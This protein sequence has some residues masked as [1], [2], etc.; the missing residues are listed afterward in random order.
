M[1]LRPA[2]ADIQG[3]SPKSLDGLPRTAFFW[4][5]SI[6]LVLNR[7]S[8]AVPCRNFL[9]SVCSMHRKPPAPSSSGFVPYPEPGE[10]EFSCP[11][12]GRA[13]LAPPVLWGLGV[14]GGASADPGACSQGLCKGF[15]L[16]CSCGSGSIPC[17]HLE[18]PTSSSSGVIL[19]GTVQLKLVLSLTSLRKCSLA[20]QYSVVIAD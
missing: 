6:Q 15:A 19:C 9:R 11:L 2:S 14:S 8:A 20:C 10:G 18:F 4:Q 3:G 13:P 12:Q 1:Q 16:C 17:T 7:R 5:V